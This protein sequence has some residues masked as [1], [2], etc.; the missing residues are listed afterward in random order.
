MRYLNR[1]SRGRRRL[2]V[3]SIIAALAV[4]AFATAA[5]AARLITLGATKSNPAPSC[6]A[7]PCQAV[8]RVTGFQVTVN[9][10]GGIFRAPAGGRLVQWSIKLSKP[11]AEQTK[12]FNNFYGSPPKARIAVLR[13]VSSSHPRFKLMRQSPTVNLTPYLGSGGQTFVLDVPLHMRKRDIA[14]LTVPTWAPAFAVNVSQ[15]TSWRAS[16]S[17]SHCNSKSDIK[18][19]SAQQKVG[20]IRSYGC[21]YKGARLLYSAGFVKG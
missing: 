8:G 7:D 19:G 4:V 2:L 6:P 9:G 12:F 1:Q 21:L 15:R 13:R 14:A 10:T 17:S 16:R 18:N 20:S 11:N 3:A 5:F